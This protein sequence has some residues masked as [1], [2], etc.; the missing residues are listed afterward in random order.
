MPESDS[1]KGASRRAALKRA[2]LAAAVAAPAGILALGAPPASAATGRPGDPL[3]PQPI[4]KQHPATEG[5]LDVPGGQLFYWDTGGRGTAVV[6]EHAGSGST[7]AWPYQQPVLAR[8]GHRVIAYSRR[9][10]YRSSAATPQD[11]PSS[12]DL[13]MLAD[14]L[15]LNRFHLLGTAYGG[16]V[17]TDFALSYPQRLLSLVIA[18]SQMGIQEPEFLDTLNRI[19]PAPFNDLPDSFKE[20][21]APY[22]VVNPQGVRDWEEITERSRPAH[23]NLAPKLAR[24]ITWDLLETIQVRTLLMAGGADLYMPPPVT[25]TLLKHLPNASL[26]TFSQ[27]GHSPH[28]EQPALYNQKLLQFLAGA[29]FPES[30]H[31]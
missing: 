11:P 2:M 17:A 5:F 1:A 19:H 9:G 31:C 26:L 25:R 24:T 12:E 8:A 20:L 3:L 4:P 14:H 10:H 23:A 29:R 28:W 7:L 22:R 13:L 27:A 16:F 18:N 6:L 15:G 30:A 21:G